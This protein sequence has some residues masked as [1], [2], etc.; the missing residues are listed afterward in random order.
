MGMNMKREFAIAGFA[1]VVSILLSSPSLA[2]TAPAKAE[3]AAPVVTHEAP[4]LEEMSLDEAVLFASSAEDR[5]RLLVR[6]I[7]PRP[8]QPDAV[9]LTEPASEPVLIA[10]Q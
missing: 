6:C 10:A 2:Q 7:G 5:K 3:P 8:R 4:V 1:L 9:A